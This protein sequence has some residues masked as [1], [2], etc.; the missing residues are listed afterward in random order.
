MS[1]P[2][3]STDSVCPAAAVTGEPS[4]SR[5]VTVPLPRVAWTLL[6]ET[7]PPNNETELTVT[8]ADL[9]VEALEVAESKVTTEP[10]AG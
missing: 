10:D 2:Q 5:P 6:A 7:A 1:C 9:H 8:D 3:P 4:I